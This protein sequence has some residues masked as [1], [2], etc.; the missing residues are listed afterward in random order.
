MTEQYIACPNCK[1][2]IL[3]DVNSLLQGASF[4]CNDCDAKIK[5]SGESKEVVSQSIENFN[6]IK[7]N[8]LKQ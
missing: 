1:N 5:L 2:N 8:A 4:G 6:N 3:F 7:T